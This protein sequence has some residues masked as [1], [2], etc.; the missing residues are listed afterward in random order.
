M[1][2]LALGGVPL[3]SH[4]IGWATWII[5]LKKRA[6]LPK[7]SHLEGEQPPGIG[8]LV[9]IVIVANYLQKAGWSSK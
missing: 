5:S 9:T 2:E 1:G 6:T 7:T 8:D 3:T 4:D